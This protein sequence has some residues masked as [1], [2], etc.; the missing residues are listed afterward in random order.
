ML[1]GRKKPRNSS[2]FAY[3]GVQQKTVGRLLIYREDL[4][5]VLAEI[6]FGMTCI[7]Y[8]ATKIFWESGVAS[9]LV[10]P[11]YKNTGFQKKNH[12][13]LMICAF[14]IDNNDTAVSEMIE[15]CYPISDYH[16]APYFI[17]IG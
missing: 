6:F 2:D 12:S 10:C 1:S 16:F 14:F 11:N 5:R 3:R 17:K 9:L 8:D 13:C 7:V 4:L 15:L